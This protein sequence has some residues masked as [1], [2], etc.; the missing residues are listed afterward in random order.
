MDKPFELHT[1]NASLQWLCTHHHLSHHQAS[2]LN[3][4]LEYDFTIT[5]ICC[6]ANVADALSSCRHT[7][8]RWSLLDQ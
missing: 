8:T 6:T 1:D 7:H 3:L 5:H 2:W 4:I